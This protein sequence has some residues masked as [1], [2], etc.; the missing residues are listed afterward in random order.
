MTQD[1]QKFG[2]YCLRNSYVLRW[3]L[4]LEQVSAFLSWSGTLFQRDGPACEKQRSPQE[5]RQRGTFRSRLFEERSCLGGLKRGLVQGIIE[6]YCFLLFPPGK[7]L[8]WHASLL[9]QRLQLRKR[10]MPKVN[11]NPTPRW[12]NPGT[13]E[14]N[15]RFFDNHSM[16]IAPNPPLC[17]DFNFT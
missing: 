11:L 6:F 13:V 14:L 7:L 1:I 5:C 8:C 12:I 2:G 3:F 10:T 4:N 15:K 17:C 16:Q 9:S